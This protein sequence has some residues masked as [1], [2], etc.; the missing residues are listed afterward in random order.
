MN[1]IEAMVRELDYEIEK[2]ERYIKYAKDEKT[3]ESI[4]EEIVTLQIKKD[5][6]LS[7]LS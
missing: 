3:R 4:K 5:I 1:N 6:W 7:F 2:L